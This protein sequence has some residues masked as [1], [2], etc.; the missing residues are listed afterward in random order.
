MK[1]GKTIVL[2]ILKSFCNALAISLLQTNVGKF[3][4]ANKLGISRPLI[5]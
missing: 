3:I 4:V 5:E 1:F 2:C